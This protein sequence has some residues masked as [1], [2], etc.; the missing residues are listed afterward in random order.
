[1][2]PEEVFNERN[3]QQRSHWNI[4][5]LKHDV[6]HSWKWLQVGQ[7]QD[8]G[9]RRSWTWKDYPDIWWV[10]S[11]SFTCGMVYAN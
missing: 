7:E 10:A 5:D 8:S 3:S 2:K 1:M 6:R 9:V 11:G 4:Y